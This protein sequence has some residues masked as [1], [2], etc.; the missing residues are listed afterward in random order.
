MNQLGINDASYANQL[1]AMGMMPSMYNQQY[2]GYD[3]EMQ[4][5]A[6]YDDLATRQQQ[7]QQD[8]WTQMHMAPVNQLMFQNGIMNGMG[9]LG[10]TSSS[11]VQAPMNFFGNTLG[12]G[13]LGAQM[14]SM[15]PG[16]GT[17]A[18]GLGGGALGFLS[19]LFG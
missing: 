8:Y 15:I 7:A 6:M 14:G 2:A 17:L 3:R 9:G 5:G 1:S 18:G 16:V 12:G 4:M 11:Q 13:M 10:G 19:S